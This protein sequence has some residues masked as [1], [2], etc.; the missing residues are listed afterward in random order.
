MPHESIRR[1]CYVVGYP[2]GTHGGSPCMRPFS[3][4]LIQDPA[5]L[6]PETVLIAPRASGEEFSTEASRGHLSDMPNL[7]VRLLPAPRPRLWRWFQQVPMLWSYLQDADLVC[8]H[9]PEELAFLT[10]L[11]CRITRKRLLVQ[12]VGDW[13]EAVLV[14]GPPGLTRTLKSWVL[15]WMNRITVRTAGL[16]FAQGQMLF[17]KSALLNPRAVKSAIAQTTLAEEAFFERKWTTFHEPLRILTVCT[18]EPRK[19]LGLLARAIHLLQASPVQ[20]EWWCVGQGPS[21]GELKELVHSLGISDS[22]RFIG[23]VPLGQKLSCIYQE[24]DVF[25]LPSY[26][27]GVPHAMLEAMASSL[28]VICSSVGGIPGAVESGVEGILLAPGRVDLLAD[29]IRQ[30]ASDP[31]AA[32][33]MGQA[34]FRKAQQLRAD[35]VTQAHRRLIEETF[36]PIEGGGGSREP[37]EASA[38]A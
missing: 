38:G 15:D 3:L 30:L 24:V 1:L 11:I 7:E 32:L 23:Y 2:V 9:V 20:V 36:G 17:E 25:V 10:A 18:L 4:R 6:F 34:G 31:A 35:G 27:E 29:A 19:G 26:H 33:R 21:E 16:V 12:V 22:V 13:K 37:L 5:I 8:V 14:S 28:P